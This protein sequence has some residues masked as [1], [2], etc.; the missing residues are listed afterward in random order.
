MYAILF[1]FAALGVALVVV[2]AVRKRCKMLQE[3]ETYLSLARE[4]I[5]GIKELLNST[6]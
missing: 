3:L 6:F 5:K 4:E 1:V 2:Y